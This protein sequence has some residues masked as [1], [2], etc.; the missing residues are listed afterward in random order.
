MT[1]SRRR[2]LTIAAS[3]A[4]VPAGAAAPEVTRWRGTA[5]G[6]AA[7]L[8][9]EG[10]APGAGRD[11]IL[12][13]QAE[14][15][16]LERIFSLYR[17]ESAL[18]RL[19]AAGRLDAPPPELLELLALAD[20]L[21]RATGGAFDPTVQP[22]FVAH[23]RAA[24]AGRT[25]TAAEIDAARAAVGWDGV[26]F[27]TR[28]VRLARPGSGLTL[29]GIAQGDIADRVAA[30]LRARGLRDVLVDTG[31]IVGRGTRGDGEPWQAGVAAP[32]GTVLAHVQLRDR[33]LAT[34]A[35]LGTV[36]DPAGRVGHIFAPATGQVA[37]TRA[38][39]AVSAPRAALADGLSTAFCL[40]P[41]DAVR[42]AIGVFPGAA[43]ET[44]L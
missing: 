23:A 27:D 5:L 38:L 39:V 37:T 36:L 25:A 40:M 10:L 18:S 42:R 3:A 1:L 4:A 21:H 29:N 13:V 7:S 15:V 30:L 16:R 24:V 20:R 12:A 19:N 28:A 17:A 11:A 35:P 9:I 2:F 43:L 41:D 44:T 31:E 32:D 34:S 8:R 26:A 22:V 14:L 6:A 33:A